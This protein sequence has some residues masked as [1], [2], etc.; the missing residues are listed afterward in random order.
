MPKRQTA[1]QQVVQ[2]GVNKEPD[3]KNQPETTNPFKRVTHKGGNPANLNTGSI[4]RQVLSTPAAVNPT[5][6]STSSQQRKQ[7]SCKPKDKNQQSTANNGDLGTSRGDKRKRCPAHQ[8][9]A[10]GGSSD[11]NPPPKRAK[12]ITQTA[13][14]AIDQERE[15]QARKQDREAAEKR[16]WER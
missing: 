5:A 14:Y 1:D 9:D 12:G 13:Q 8:M 3:N 10:S 11:N 2:V 15:K 7:G 6:K 4:L 16:A